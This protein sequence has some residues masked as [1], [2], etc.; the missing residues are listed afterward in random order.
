MKHTRTLRVL[1]AIS[2]AALV[3]CRY[4]RGESDS[5]SDNFRVL[6]AN[7]DGAVDRYEWENL[8]GSAFP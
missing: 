7:H 3:G 8:Q 5:P 4:N 6:D 2:I 1:C